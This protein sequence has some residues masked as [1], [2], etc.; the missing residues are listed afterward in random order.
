MYDQ[1]SRPRVD[2]PRGSR[3]GGVLL[4]VSQHRCRLSRTRAD[5]IVGLSQ[6]LLFLVLSHPALPAFAQKASDHRCSDPPSSDRAQPQPPSSA[7]AL[8]GTVSGV[9]V[10]RDGTVYEGA[11]ISLLAPTPAAGQLQSS[12]RLATSDSAGHF[13][14]T[15]VPSGPFQLTV[16]FAGFATQTISAFLHPGESYEGKPIVLPV[17][18]TSEVRVSASREEIAEAQVKLEEQ[19]RVLGVIPNYYVAYDPDAAPLSTRQKVDLALR[20]SV[21][22]VSFLAAGAFAGL[23]QATNSFSGYGQGAQGYAKRYGANYADLFVGN[24]VSGAVFPAIFKQD[25]RYF[26]K[27]IGTVRSRALYAVA[28]SV[29]CR[30]DNRRWQPNYSSILG[31]LAAGGISNLYY[32]A[33]NRDGVEL[34]FE[35]AGIGV[36][37]GA[38]E[39]LLQEFVVR[40]LTPK[41]PNY[42]SAKP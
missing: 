11:H 28:M 8:A 31:G 15:S 23:Q 9:V 30:G 16:S 38:V 32:P 4:T 41:V 35:N 29:V 13:N 7:P 6:G 34:T 25:P 12:G 24:M 39:N 17:T 19:Q 3:E 21:D 2:F 26:Y 18:T 42:N 33:S 22:P 40:K 20:S 37:E 14:F 10:D 5:G 36:V 1:F 27:G